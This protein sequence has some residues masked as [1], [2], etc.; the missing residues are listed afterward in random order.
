MPKGLHIRGAKAELAFVLLYTLAI[1]I[2]GVV[3]WLIW[4]LPACIALGYAFYVL[5]GRPRAEVR[6][7]VVVCA[8]VLVGNLLV[9]LARLD[10]NPVR[11]TMWFDDREYMVQSSALAG[12]WKAHIFPDISAKGSE[13][14]FM[15]TLHT[16]YQ[17]AVAALFYVSGSAAPAG[18]VLNA[19]AGS[20]IP[21]FV[22]L[23][24]GE[25]ATPAGSRVPWLA[26]LLAAVHP[27]QY[28]WGMFL[29]KDVYT[30]AWFVGALWLLVRALRLRDVAAGLAFAGCC[31]ILFTIRVYCAASLVFAGLVYA[32]SGLARRTAYFSL[33]AGALVLWMI[34]TY[35]DAGS[36]RFEQMWSS[37]TELGPK[38]MQSVSQMGLH[39]LAGIP[40]L[41]LGPFAWL[42]GRGRHPLYGLYPGMWYLYLL[43]YPAAST[44]L[45][46]VVR[47]DEK[48]WAVPLMT[49]V[50]GALI[51]LTASYGGDAPRQ[52]FYM[53]YVPV[54]LASYGLTLP[55]R[56]VF[57]AWYLALAAYMVG[58]VITVRVRGL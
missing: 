44:A 35:T 36:T 51:L 28:Y 37:L 18:L 8:S 11:F 24:M 25:L 33:A 29:M 58:Q 17:R 45:V 49:V 7:V 4:L 34:C 19:I 40:R 2:R 32:A 43:I 30:A 1:S 50:G 53:E 5:H 10:Y 31:Y 13:A 38:H 15:G 22:F 57:L 26:C 47:R 27:N 46:A 12:A 56:R 55:K 16:G 41:L 3:P 54:A 39:V 48:L 9:L 14:Y 21:L 20:L 52:R 23:L 6:M 42:Q